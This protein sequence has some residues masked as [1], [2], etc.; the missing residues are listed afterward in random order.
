MTS[1]PDSRPE[2]TDILTDSVFPDDCSDVLD[3]I[4][5]DSDSASFEYYFQFFLKII[6]G[7]DPFIQIPNMD[8]SVIISMNWL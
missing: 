8:Q 3:R 4:E 1:S 5:I 2:D 7:I 6:S